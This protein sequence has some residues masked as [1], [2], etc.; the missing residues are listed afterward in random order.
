MT[1]E[2]KKKDAKKSFFEV[3]APMTSTRISLYAASPEALHGKHVL[4]DLTRSLRGKNLV[5]SLRVIHNQG[6]LEAEP[7]Q[8]E[9]VGS[10]IRRMMRKGADYVEDSF[11]VSCKDASMVIKPFLITRNKV[12][13]AVRRE[14]RNKAREH[15]ISH[16]TTR[17][18]KELFTELISG[19]IQK[20]L[21]L[22]LKKTYPLALCE[23]RFF[24]IAKQKQEVAHVKK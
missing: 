1:V 12:S 24:G 17:T 23:I 20:D 22:K 21:S 2:T 7:V 15:L 16:V 14:L 6:V 11:V 5:L 10:Y 4:L 19:K 9:L 3:K 13:R 8:L 18:M